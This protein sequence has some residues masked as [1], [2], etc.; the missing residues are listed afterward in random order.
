VNFW[1]SLKNFKFVFRFQE[2]ESQLHIL[3]N[4]AGLIG[5]P[6]AKTK[7]GF[8]TTMG[9]NHLGHFLLTHLLLDTLKASAPSRIVNVSS[10]AYYFSKIE[11][12]FFESD[13]KMTSFTAYAKSKLAQILFTKAMA[14]RLEGTSV[15]VNSCH[16]GMKL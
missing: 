13:R 9:V 14:K 16:P 2:R 7:D 3:I 15:T 1:I 4:N 8:E 11:R 12:D 6:N 5:N 10:S